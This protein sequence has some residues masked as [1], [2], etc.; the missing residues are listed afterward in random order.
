[1]L[2]IPVDIPSKY[3]PLVLYAFFCLFSGLVLSYFL[4]IV[5]GYCYATG[6]I[7]KLKV[8]DTRLGQSE[9]TGI[10]S[11]LSR[12]FLKNWFASTLFTLCFLFF[13]FPIRRTGWVPIGSALGHQAWSVQEPSQGQ[14]R[15]SASSSGVVGT[16]GGPRVFGYGEDQETGS[17]NAT[18]EKQPLIDQVDSLVLSIFDILHYIRNI[19]LRTISSQDLVA[20][21]RQGEV[22][23][24]PLESRSLP[25]D[26][27]R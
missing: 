3:F 6:Y 24:P 11:G 23:P 26:W 20:L 22:E 4:S 15:Q 17:S 16:R 10:L 18:Q 19:C 1:M 21:C 7:D 12:Y 5:V 27:L 8:S 25:S 14:S 9:A 13:F 2:F